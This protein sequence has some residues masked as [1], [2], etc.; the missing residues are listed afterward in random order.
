MR[1]TDG[2]VTWSLTGGVATVLLQRP[3][4]K[5][6]L[7]AAA[8]AGIG[9]ATLA[10]AHAGARALILTGAGGAF[11]AGM[12]LKPDNPLLARAAAGVLDQN[13]PALRA[14]IEELKASLATL[15]G[16]PGPTVAAIEGVCLG[17]GLEVALHCDLRIC[18]EDAVLSLPEPHIGF[19]PDVG[20]ATLLKRLVGPARAT[21]LTLS[22][23]RIDAKTAAAWG[24]VEELAPPGGALAAA[25]AWVAD[26]LRAAPTASREVLGLMRGDLQADLAHETEAGVAA[27]LSGEVL[28]GV[29]A[30][31]EGRPPRWA[32]PE[33]G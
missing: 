33:A 16:F 9:E 3:R 15:R 26:A 2:P 13:G 12:D 6:A 5:N 7:D 21:W 22:G 19:V 32:R 28:E 29:A 27:L 14:L 17:G 25:E 30:F 11:S 24:L 23:R 10:A 1:P 18:A 31:A 4:R 8:W 20:G